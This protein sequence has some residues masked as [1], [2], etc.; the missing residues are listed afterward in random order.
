MVILAALTVTV[1]VSAVN[2]AAAAEFTP[3][4]NIAPVKGKN[5]IGLLA[6]CAFVFLPAALRIKEDIKWHSLR[7]GI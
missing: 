6:Y 7:S 5:I 3:A 4:F 1:I 2:G